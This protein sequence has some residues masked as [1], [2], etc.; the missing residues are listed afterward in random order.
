[1]RLPPTPYPLPPTSCRVEAISMPHVRDGAMNKYLVEA[2]SR[3][4]RRCPITALTQEAALGHRAVLDQIKVETATLRPSAPLCSAPLC[5][6]PL[7][8]LLPL[9]ASGC[10]QHCP[11]ACL[12][13]SVRPSQSATTTSWTKSYA[14][15]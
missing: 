14:R 13:Y 6:A 3:L 12:R 4:A 5:S 7:A 11:C 1:M 8:L 2:Q 10:R 9:P 15:S